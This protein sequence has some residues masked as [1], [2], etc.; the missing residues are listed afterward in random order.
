MSSAVHVEPGRGLAVLTA[1]QVRTLDEWTAHHLGLP[2]LML[3]ERAALGVVDA[4]LAG[5]A[6]AAICVL[7]G[8]GNNGGDGLA[9]ARMLALRG[10]RV[11]VIVTSEPSRATADAAVQLNACQKLGIPLLDLQDSADI[12]SVLDQSGIIVDAICGTGLTT[13]LRAPQAALIQT[14]LKRRPDAF[15]VAV[16]VPSNINADTG[17]VLGAVLPARITVTFGALRWAHVLPP[18]LDFLGEL[19]VADIG[20]MPFE[21]EDETFGVYPATVLA[22][23]GRRNRPSDYKGVRGHVLVVGGSPTMVGAGVLAARAALDAGAGLVTLCAPQESTS[24]LAGSVPEV[25]TRHDFPSD[26]DAERYTSVVVGP[27]L[28][29]ETATEFLR[30]LTPGVL[31]VCPVVIDAGALDAWRDLGD[32]RP[33]GNNV[34]ITPHPGELR[35]LMP[36]APRDWTLVQLARQCADDYGVV[37][38]AKTSGALIARPHNPAIAISERGHEATGRG[39]AGDVLAG[40]IGALLAHRPTQA[41]DAAVIGCALHAQASHLAWAAAGHDFLPSDLSRHVPKARALRDQGVR[42]S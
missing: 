8:T 2:T 20:L 42:E 39:G 40:I 21:P 27:G 22:R 32:E 33:R 7:A 26:W 23:A 15:I 1:A 12:D 38:V 13:P 5:P 29:R 31:A 14:V 41:F 18:A 25:M 19:R 36:D 16:D 24:G 17:A 34:V 28:V 35:R 11:S 9:A 37:V 30:L 10:R 4:V 6:D 3:M